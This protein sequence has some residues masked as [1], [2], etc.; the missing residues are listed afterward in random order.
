MSKRDSV[1]IFALAITLVSISI[2]C[3]RNDLSRSKA[4]S[5]LE[6]Y[7]GAITFNI[8]KKFAVK[9][10]SPPM[11]EEK[12]PRVREGGSQKEKQMLIS[13]QKAGYITIKETT[14]KWPGPAG[15]YT[16]YWIISGTEKL[17]PYIVKD[18][19]GI[20]E[21]KVA[22][23]VID[24]ITG[25]TRDGNIAHIDYTTRVKPN[26]LGKIIPV[27]LRKQNR[28]ASFVLYDDGWRLSR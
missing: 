18:I 4:K 25:I 10:V 15:F 14:K 24:E 27:D 3:S 11:F 13:L 19:H 17:K 26:S 7:P 9:F 5:I 20:I 12:Q 8:E 6:K 28:S 1:F 16:Y 2:A 21:V 23:V 22:D